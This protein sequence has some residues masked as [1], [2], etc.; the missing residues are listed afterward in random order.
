[1]NAGGLLKKWTIAASRLS[2]L[3]LGTALVARSF[4]EIGRLSSLVPLELSLSP[5]RVFARR[6]E[7]PH[8]VAIERPRHADAGMHQRS[9]SFAESRAR[10]LHPVLLTPA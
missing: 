8:D 7:L 6:V 9:A 5:M 1:M 10:E 3:E 4:A 2:T